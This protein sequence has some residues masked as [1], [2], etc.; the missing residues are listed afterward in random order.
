MGRFF[1]GGRHRQ[2]LLIAADPK[3]PESAA[4]LMLPHDKRQCAPIDV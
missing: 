1:V 2:Q 4:A 3:R